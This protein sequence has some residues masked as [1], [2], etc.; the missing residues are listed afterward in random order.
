MRQR[1]WLWCKFLWVMF[2]FAS[3]RRGE[4]DTMGIND[5]GLV[6]RDRKTRKDAFYFYQ[7]N[8]S[9]KPVLHITSSRYN[10]RP[11][12]PM[13]VKVYSNCDQL[14]LFVDKQSVGTRNGGEFVYTWNVTLAP[15][16][17]KVQV[18]A[19]KNGKKH[20]DEVNWE[21]TVTPPATRATRG[22]ESP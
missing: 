9:E 8:W 12:G 6:T 19:M 14:E 10:P 16:K 11:A 20:R 1:D 13:Q 17:H 15:G 21:V 2:D 3:D 18:V 5:K 7:A 22:V 4:G